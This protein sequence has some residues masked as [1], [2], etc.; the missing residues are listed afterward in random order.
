MSQQLKDNLRLLIKHHPSYSAVLAETIAEVEDLEKVRFGV[1]AARVFKAIDRGFQQDR[2]I[3]RVTGLELAVVRKI[4][5]MAFEENLLR[6]EEQGGK[7]DGA[8]GARK[9]LYQRND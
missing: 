6:T 9:K 2:E 1:P 8:R 3:A 5:K 4:L 7:T